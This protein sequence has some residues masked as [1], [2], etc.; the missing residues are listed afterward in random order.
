MDTDMYRRLAL[1]HWCH[2]HHGQGRGGYC[3]TQL[4]GTHIPASCC[5]CMYPDELC[6]IDF[7]VA[8]EVNSR[9][10]PCAMRLV[11]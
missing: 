3:V 1:T 2:I 10:E 11:S 6:P 9:F 4:D 8:E 7:H 5:R